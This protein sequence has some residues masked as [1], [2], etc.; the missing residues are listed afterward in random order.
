MHRYSFTFSENE[1]AWL[2]LLMA[3]RHKLVLLLLDL[4]VACLQDP[5]QQTAAGSREED[6]HLRSMSEGKRRRKC[7]CREK[8]G[9]ELT[10]LPRK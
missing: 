8:E 3:Y 10:T 6:H 4:F 9:S 1:L 7:E 2:L 5:K